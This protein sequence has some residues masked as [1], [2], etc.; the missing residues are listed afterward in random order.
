MAICATLSTFAVE[1]VEY[2]HSGVNS[3]GNKSD[4][5]MYFYPN[6][7]GWFITVDPV[8]PLENGEYPWGTTLTL[9]DEWDELTFKKEGNK[10]SLTSFQFL[11]KKNAFQEIMWEME[12]EGVC[13]GTE[14]HLRFYYNV[15][16][17]TSLFEGGST[18]PNEEDGEENVGD[19]D[20]TFT[21]ASNPRITNFSNDI[22]Y[23]FT[24]EDCDWAIEVD[25]L[26]KAITYGKTYTHSEMDDSGCLAKGVGD[27][28]GN[29]R[30][31][32]V[33]F[34]VVKV[35]GEDAY[36]IEAVLYKMWG[37]DRTPKLLA[38]SSNWSDSAD[39]D[40]DGN[41]EEE[42]EEEEEEGPSA[43]GSGTVGDPYI[44]TLDTPCPGGENGGK[45]SSPINV[46]YE[47]TAESDGLLTYEYTAE[48]S[49][50]VSMYYGSSCAS[51]NRNFADGVDV[52]AGTEYFFKMMLQGS[53][54]SVTFHQ[55]EGSLA[56]VAPQLTMA[57]NNDTYVGETLKTFAST[58]TLVFDKKCE[59]SQSGV[60]YLFNGEEHGLCNVNISGMGATITVSGASQYLKQAGEHTIHI[61]A[62]AFYSTDGIIDMEETELTWTATGLA[63]Y[64][65]NLTT[66][67]YSS[68]CWDKNWEAP[69]GVT[70]YIATSQESEMILIE[71]VSG[72]ISAG[73]GVILYAVGPAQITVEESEDDADALEG[74]ILKGTTEDTP[75][76]SGTIYAMHCVNGTTVFDK[77][78][79]SQ[80]LANKAY[81]QV[82]GAS[83]ARLRIQLAGNTATDIENDTALQNVVKK[84]MVNG[85]LVIVRDGAM[86]N[87][88]GVKVNE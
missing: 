79:G 22:Y 43:E 40:G 8:A 55:S 11:A 60:T 26:G 74:N 56:T 41:E 58:T 82:S 27:Y 37:D 45:Y 4:K 13:A 64:N 1:N 69:A 10:M 24:C 49:N 76:P 72:V 30:M 84:M 71:E 28:S 66:D 5:D 31:S 50:A 73:E 2:Q 17:G 15:P 51:A 34:T 70:V 67:G 88:Q 59:Y 29:W 42:E 86:Y 77:Y 54:T 78:T 47:Y 39:S 63:K 18:P 36:K 16:A 62:G 87:V 12:A 33:N 3:W 57:K 65:V 35:N 48:G 19:Y 80:I 32:E 68:F 25:P 61:A 14:Y 6:G 75:T 81:I 53:I 46:Y 38:V 52:T 20:I 85:T 21:L 83:S 7:S 44:I 9:D 23:Q